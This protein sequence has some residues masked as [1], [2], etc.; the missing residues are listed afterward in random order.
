MNMELELLCVGK[1][2]KR[3]SLKK[4]ILW[5][6]K[7]GPKGLGTLLVGLAA[8]WGALHA[9]ELFEKVLE[10]RQGVARLEEGV[11]ALKQALIASK[12]KG[13]AQAPLEELQHIIAE[14]P[15]SV[16]SGIYLDKD[17]DREALIK[18]LQNK[19]VE[20]REQILQNALQYKLPSD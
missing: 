1:R 4:V 12:A 19:T 10:I 11:E 20:Q 16:S 14:I 18:T 17:K 6:I 7:D 13:I 15:S 2:W 5:P 8:A 9:N 3:V